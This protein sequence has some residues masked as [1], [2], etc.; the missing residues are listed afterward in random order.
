MDNL[1][2]LS[3]ADLERRLQKSLENLEELEEEKRYVLRQTGLHVSGGTVLKY[4]SQ[5]ISLSKS[6]E[7]FKEELAR[8]E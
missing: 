6:I 4:E 1:S 2:K 3:D 8:R 7:A 5:T